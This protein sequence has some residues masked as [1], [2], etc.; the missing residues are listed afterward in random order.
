M[1]LVYLFIDYIY[2]IYYVSERLFK[3]MAENKQKCADQRRG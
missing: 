3:R 2:Y 1:K